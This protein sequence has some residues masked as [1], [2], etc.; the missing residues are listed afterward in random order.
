MSRGNQRKTVRNRQVKR[1][2]AADPCTSE[3][4]LGPSPLRLG[5]VRRR[6]DAAAV[7]GPVSV[8][9]FATRF[10]DALIRVRPE[11]IALRL[12][13]V[14]GEARGAVSIVE[15][16]G[17]RKCRR[18]NS[19]LDCVNERLTPIHLVLV[20]S[21]REEIV[22][23]KVVELLIGVERLFDVSEENRTNDA[24]AAPH[25]RDSAHVEIPASFFFGGAKQHI[26]LRVAHHLRTVERAAHVLD[27]FG[28]QADGNL[29]RL[30]SPQN[31]RRSDAL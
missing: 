3:R 23:Q 10:V 12:Q 8:K 9:E 5:V 25:E 1:I 6:R 19:K 17:R 21:A 15:R 29:V 27:E 30:W 22:R 13:K 20:E 16:Q 18:R 4:S 26:T 7:S 31:R 24:T 28:L 2:A 14:G 11:E